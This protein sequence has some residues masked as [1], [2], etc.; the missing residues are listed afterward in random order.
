MRKRY[1]LGVILAVM[2]C[3]AAGIMAVSAAPEEGVTL[4]NPSN[5]SID[6]KAYKGDLVRKYYE[7]EDGE[8]IGEEKSRLWWTYARLGNNIFSQNFSSQ[9]E[10][11]DLI[12]AAESVRH[13]KI[14][15]W[16]GT[17]IDS[18][19][20]VVFTYVKDVEG[21]RK[22]IDA[23][24]GKAKVFLL[25][26]QYNKSQLKSWKNKLTEEIK[27]N[28]EL[29]NLWS[30]TS[31]G[32]ADNKVHVYFEELNSSVFKELESILDKSEIPLKGVLVAEQQKPEPTSRDFRFRPLIGGIQTL[33]YSAGYCTLGFTAELDG[34]TGFITAGHCCEL[35]EDVYQP[36]DDT[37]NVGFAS[38]VRS[39]YSDSCW[40][41]ARTDANF[42]I[43]N[44]YDPNN[45]YTVVGDQHYQWQGMEVCF[46]GQKSGEKCG[47]ITQVN[48]DVS[49]YKDQIVANF[50]CQNGDS[51]APVYDNSWVTDKYIYGV[52][53][54][55]GGEGIS[56]YSPIYGIENDIGSL[57]TS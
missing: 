27:R 22:V 34:V 49:G 5:L 30:G 32:Y 43:Y 47:Y 21:G 38:V 7:Y 33:T 10:Y 4:K 29:S 53:W 25:K 11:K 18:E 17:F 8:W 9:D 24:N 20:G 52:L 31:P 6:Q 50:T 37:D 14:P 56:Y 2:V 48:I 15:S 19:K 13:A 3:T 42:M 16:G 54:G 12:E 35:Y 28:E 23:V 41:Q 36:D 55:T 51:G 57:K 39:T 26:G 40:V 1:L 44:E 46:G 45:P